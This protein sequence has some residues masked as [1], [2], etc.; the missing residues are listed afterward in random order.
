[1]G[2][3]KAIQESSSLIDCDGVGS[4]RLLRLQSYFRSGQPRS[5]SSNGENISG[6]CSSFGVPGHCKGIGSETGGSSGRLQFGFER[7]PFFRRFFSEGLR[8]AY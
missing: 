8:G 6:D 3:S 4:R 2:S 1:M 7:T 5:G